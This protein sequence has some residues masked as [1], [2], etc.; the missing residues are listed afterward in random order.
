MITFQMVAFAASVCEILSDKSIP[1][2]DAF[3]ILDALADSF[4]LSESQVDFILDHLEAGLPV[5]CH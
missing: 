5:A 3:A 4:G 1:D 2:G